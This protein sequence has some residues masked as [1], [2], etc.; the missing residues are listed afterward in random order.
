MP[1]Y[2]VRGNRRGGL[3]PITLTLQRIESLFQQVGFDVVEGPE[4]EDDYHN[5][6]ALKY[7]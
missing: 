1:P 2:P 5:F 4:V 7:S 6:G 3:H